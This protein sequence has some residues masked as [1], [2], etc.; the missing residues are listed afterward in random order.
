MR[1]SAI[2]TTGWR[3]DTVS[4]LRTAT[5]SSRCSSDA[6]Q[7]AEHQPDAC[8]TFDR[9]LR[10]TVSLR[11]VRERYNLAAQRYNLAARRHPAMASAWRF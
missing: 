4:D 7:R 6:Y 9:R 10:T 5:D 3:R 11:G 1:R 2:G 8:R